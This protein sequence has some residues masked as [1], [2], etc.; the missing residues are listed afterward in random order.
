MYTI[1]QHP[2]CGS[3]YWSQLK[4]ITRQQYSELGSLVHIHQLKS[5]LSAGLDDPQFHLELCVFFSMYRSPYECLG[6]DTMMCMAL[7]MSMCVHR[8]SYNLP[9][10]HTF[11]PVRKLLALLM[12]PWDPRLSGNSRSHCRTCQVY[13]FEE[14]FATVRRV[15]LIFAAH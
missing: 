11:C 1:P 12:W 9:A 5:Q 7:S 3:L 8:D 10:S 4:V 13:E 14:D 6:L 15:V 2:N